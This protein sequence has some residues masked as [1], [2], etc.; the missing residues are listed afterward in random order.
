MPM[1]S[2]EDLKSV[3]TEGHGPAVSIFLPTHR[4]GPDIQQDS[5]RLKNLLKQAES[6]LVREGNQA[7]RA[8]PCTG[9]KFSTPLAPSGRTIMIAG[10][11]HGFTD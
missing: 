3:V 10:G 11:A 9:F 4:V 8:R 7:T 6:E 1:L 2:P 5:I